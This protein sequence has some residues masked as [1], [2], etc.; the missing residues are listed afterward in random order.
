MFGTTSLKF[1]YKRLDDEHKGL[2]KIMLEVE[3]NPNE[4]A[5]VDE[6]QKLMRNH[7]YYEEEQFCDSIDL[8][9]D[10]CKEHK[11]KHVLFSER[12]AKMN[13]PVKSEEIKWAQD[14]LA[15]H[16][17]NTDFGYKGHLKHPVPEPYVW[18]ESF[19]TD[20]TRLD[21]EHDILFAQI[22]AV[23]QHPE[24][25]GKLAELK[26]GM[27]NHFQYEEQRYCS[28]EGY[29]CVDHKMKHYKFWV[30]LDDLEAPINCE[31]INWAKNW[32]AQHIKNTDHGYKLRLNGPDSGESMSGAL[33]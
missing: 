28:V 20:Y 24:D 22:L 27:W 25:A 33:P 5:K 13:A 31:Q 11:K 7:F 19:A 30:I 9:W 6:L 10:Y 23:S 14:W 21:D 1:F 29:A 18:D 15:Q 3:Q 2:F 4:Q 12:F 16:I 17:K 32:L 8:P 26:K